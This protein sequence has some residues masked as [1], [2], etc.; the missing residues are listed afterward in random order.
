MSTCDLQV[1]L[2]PEDDTAPRLFPL[3]FHLDER[4]DRPGVFPSGWVQGEIERVLANGRATDLPSSFDCEYHMI[5]PCLAGINSDQIYCA[6]TPFMCNQCI[7]HLQKC[8]MHQT[9]I[10]S[11]YAQ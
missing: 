8:P 9:L 11:I 7:L 2:F 3:K 6:Y 10:F 1:I 5:A 4:K